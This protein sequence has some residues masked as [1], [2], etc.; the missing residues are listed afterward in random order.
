V[1]SIADWKLAV[2]ARY[3]YASFLSGLRKDKAKLHFIP[4]NVAP[5]LQLDINNGVLITEDEHIQFHT[6][7]GHREKAAMFFEEWVT[8]NYGIDSTNFP[9]RSPNA[10]EEIYALLQKYQDK[11]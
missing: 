3:N 1:A 6:A 5:H 10:R 8:S 7:Y 9:W 4:V 2:Q 11:R